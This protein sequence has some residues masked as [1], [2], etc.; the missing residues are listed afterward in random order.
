MVN[1]LSTD[2][3]IKGKM[4]MLKGIIEKVIAGIIL[5]VITGAIA[6]RHYSFFMK[7]RNWYNR[8][9]NNRIEKKAKKE[10]EIALDKPITKREMIDIMKANSKA[11]ENILNITR[12]TL[13]IL[14]QTINK[15]DSQVLFE[16]MHRKGFNATPQ[17]KDIERW[18]NMLWREHYDG[19]SGELH[20]A[21]KIKKLEININLLKNSIHELKSEHDEILRDAHNRMSKRRSIFD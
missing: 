10:A 7:I 6:N 14:V 1:E 3:L 5:L 20:T 15:P 12:L 19:D 2:F 8:R 17:I 21:G 4:A 18:L 16:F 9:R 13:C 11:M